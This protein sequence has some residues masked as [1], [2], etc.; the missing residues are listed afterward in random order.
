MRRV[1]RV[2]FLSFMCAL[3]TLPMAARAERPSPSGAATPVQRLAVVRTTFAGEVTA[4][5]QDVF[6]AR[7]V[8]G[9]AVA[10]FQVMSGPPVE[11]KLGK[12]AHCADGD[13]YPDIAR[14]LDVGYL[15]VGHIEESNK[16][17]DITLELIN[18]RTGATIGKSRERCETCGM[19]EAGE[20]VS[21]AAVALRKRLESLASTPSRIVINS[22]P[23]GATAIVDGGPAGRTPVE[24]E[25][26][27]GA[28][29]LSLAL[30]GHHTVNRSFTVVS[31]VDE[32]LNVDMF[33]PHGS[34][35]YRT[36]GWIAVIGGVAM[37]GAGAYAAYIDGQTIACRPQ[38]QDVNGRC[39]LLRDTD[40]VAALLVGAGAAMATLGGVSLWLATEEAS[41]AQ[42]AQRHVGLRYANRF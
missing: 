22:R 20:K 29:R 37:I 27:G 31:G 21:L 19:A 17:Y 30:E 2:H 33:K 15:L 3:L 24:V 1:K 4:G 11:R 25:L 39:P 32:T 28:H 6:A 42:T 10:A 13:C 38:Q 36:V 12:L 9:L 18:G 14:K 40:A 35:P 34:F 7:L 23:G 16:N 41:A 5:H 8:E 26:P